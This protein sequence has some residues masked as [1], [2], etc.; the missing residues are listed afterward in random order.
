MEP[1]DGEREEAGR[2]ASLVRERWIHALGAGSARR[3][4]KT[5][6]ATRPWMPENRGKRAGVCANPERGWRIQVV[7]GP[8]YLL[9]TQS[10]RSRLAA[11]DGEE[12]EGQG[13]TEEERRDR[14][15]VFRGR[16]GPPHADGR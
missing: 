13:T 7:G 16:R 11:D 10:R 2:H 15:P 14:L 9:A 8:I 12:R 5:V 6:G 1:A 4:P 3:P